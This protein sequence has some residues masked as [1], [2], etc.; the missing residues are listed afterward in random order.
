MGVWAKDSKTD[1]AHMDSND[2]YGSE[3]STILEKRITLK[4]LL[5]EKMEKRLF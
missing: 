3:V 4:F 5:L 2:F 1:V